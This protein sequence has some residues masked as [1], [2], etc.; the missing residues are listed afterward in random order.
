MA[1]SNLILYLIFLII[2]IIFYL[3]WWYIIFFNWQGFKSFKNVLTKSQAV[4]Y[5]SYCFYNY[6]IAKVN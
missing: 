4:K 3:N 6:G 2:P 1:K 5:F